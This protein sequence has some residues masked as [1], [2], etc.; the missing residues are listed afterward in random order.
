MLEDTC[1]RKQS[2]ITSYV[3]RSL[4]ARPVVEAD[5]VAHAQR[6]TLKQTRERVARSCAGEMEREVNAILGPLGVDD[7]IS[8]RVAGSL[9]AVEATLPPPLP[10]PTI[11]RQCLNAVARRPKFAGV[12]GGRDEER[13]SL[14]RNAAEESARGEDCDEK[15]LTA[16]LLKFGEG[17]EETTDSRLFVS[18][19]T[20][21]LSCE[22]FARSA[23]CESRSLQS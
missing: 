4:S 22:F 14:L 20:I 19:I 11:F 17:M 6:Y 15:G 9:L 23:Q 3:A 2:G 1:R 16:F 12:G 13:T 21:G 8:R 7:A 18:A 10:H 5:P